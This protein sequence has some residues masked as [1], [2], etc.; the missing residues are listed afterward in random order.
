M[1]NGY[2]LIMNLSYGLLPHGLLEFIV[3]C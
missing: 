3:I 2:C 1:K